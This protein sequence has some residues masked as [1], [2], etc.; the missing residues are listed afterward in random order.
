MV[1]GKGSTVTASLVNSQTQTQVAKTQAPATDTAGTKKS[2]SAAASQ[3]QSNTQD[4][5]S[6]AKSVNNVR[7]DAVKTNDPNKTD[8]KDQTGKIENSSREQQALDF[9]EAAATL[10]E[11]VD[12]MPSD[13]KF[14]VDE[15]TDRLILK[16]VNPVTKEVV[17]QFPPEELLSMAKRLRSMTDDQT[18]N[19]IFINTR[20]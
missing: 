15:D 2:I 14:N 13:L 17:K 12:K 19:G 8:E 1:S 18:N 5:T 6:T 16:I 9:K 3:I 20:S 11:Y 7:S 4:S 10:K